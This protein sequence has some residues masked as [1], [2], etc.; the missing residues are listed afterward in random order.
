M[1]YQHNQ[2]VAAS[3]WDVTHNLLTPTPIVSV[4][5]NY[6]GATTLV[7][8]K[9]VRVTDPNSIQIIFTQSLAGVAVIN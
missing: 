6:N 4:W 9:T 1:S 5:I 8:P 2:T 3:V 7:M